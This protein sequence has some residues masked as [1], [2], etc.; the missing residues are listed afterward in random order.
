M[1]YK[2]KLKLIRWFKKLIRFDETKQTSHFAKINKYA[3]KT[4]VHNQ[5]YSQKDINVL[6]LDQ[7]KYHSN[8]NLIS[9][10]D[11]MNLIKYEKIKYPYSVKNEEVFR[12]TLTV[13]VP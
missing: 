8:L 11:K 4:I 5:V 1:K 12:A 9:E 13:I 10:L 3:I 7:L 6:A 2:T